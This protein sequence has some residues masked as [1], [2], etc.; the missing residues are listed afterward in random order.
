MQL[1]DTVDN[2]VNEATD[3]N[4]TRAMYELL[5]HRHPA[6]E[7][8]TFAELNI[9]TGSNGGRWIDL[10]AMNCFPS[11][12][13]LKIAYEIKASRA[14]FLREMRQPNK[15][16]AAE[17]LADECYFV[18]PHGL[19][20]ADEV[21]EGWGLIV[22]NKGGLRMVKQAKQRRVGDLPISFVLSIARR[23]SDPAPE[24]PAAVWVHAG[25]EIPEDKLRDMADQA[26]QA[27]IRDAEWKARDEVRKSNEYKLLQNIQDVIRDVLGY[28]VS[29]SP[30]LLRSRLTANQ[31]ERKPLNPFMGTRMREAI[32]DLQGAL[33]E[34]KDKGYL[35]NSP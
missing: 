17:K 11:K 20:A 26:T 29:I 28:R 33:K 19:L 6:P 24:L 31:G 32:N 3:A 27:A 5:K 23:S 13:N 9:G 18:A 16:A 1:F 25:Q 21:P 7:W 30:E 10:Y 22:M 15:R 2:E 4:K 12:G 14:D 8:A 34:L 35:D